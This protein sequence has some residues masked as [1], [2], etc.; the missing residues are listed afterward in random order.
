MRPPAERPASGEPS[1]T[2]S[3]H[4]STRAATAC[5]LIGLA[6][7]C[8][9]GLIDGKLIMLGLSKEPPAGLKAAAS[10]AVSGA[11]PD[12]LDRNG[13]VMATDI[14][15][16]S[17]FA[18]PRR[19]IDKDEAVE[20]PH[21]RSARCRCARPA[22]APR[23]AQG[24]RLGEARRYAKAAGGSL[25]PRPAGRWLPAREQA[26]L[27]EWTGGGPRARLHQHRQSR[28]RGYR[29]VGRQPGPRRP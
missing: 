11:R 6:F 1:P 21:R 10:D 20:L 7:L 27:S 8:V 17:V 16:M 28:H 24:L 9:Y 5:R 22:H 12:L 13:E 3:A 4:G 25:P 29:E 14:K 18:E 23:L 19:I 26:H 15:T 2:C